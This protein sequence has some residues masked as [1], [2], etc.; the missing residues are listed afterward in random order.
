MKVF[1]L[2]VLATLSSLP[3]DQP[4]PS[5]TPLESLERREW[6]K[7]SKEGGQVVINFRW[8][9]TETADE[10]W[11]TFRNVELEATVLP[12]VPKPDFDWLINKRVYQ[13]LKAAFGGATVAQFGG[14][15]KLEELTGF[16]Q[17]SKTEKEIK[18]WADHGF[19]PQ[20]ILRF[21]LRVMRGQD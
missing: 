14:D 6:V 1:L 8:L 20:V 11:L 16:T 7:G 5:T 19:G 18:E 12:G 17:T 2:A 21:E 3:K 15:R 10:V 4:A 9:S 13:V